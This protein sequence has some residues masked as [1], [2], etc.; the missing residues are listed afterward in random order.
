MVG[1]CCLEYDD[2]KDA[3]RT[4][5]IILL[6]TTYGIGFLAALFLHIILPEDA[7][8]P[9]DSYAE[10]PASDLKYPTAGQHSLALA[11]HPEPAVAEA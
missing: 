11:G 6:K 2:T 3:N 4:T 8:D 7:V 10:N 1:F 9:D 5:T